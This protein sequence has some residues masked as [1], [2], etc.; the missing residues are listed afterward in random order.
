[1]AAS[2]TTSTRFS[3][4][5]IWY[6]VIREIVNSISWTTDATPAVIE[7]L[8]LDRTGI[9]KTT[10]DEDD[11]AILQEIYA[12]TNGFQNAVGDSITPTAD[13]DEFS[14]TVAELEPN[15]I[16]NPLIAGY[17]DRLENKRKMRGYEAQD[18]VKAKTVG[19]R[20]QIEQGV[21][22]VTKDFTPKT[23]NYNYP[24]R[25]WLV[26]EETSTQ[27]WV[28][29]LIPK[30]H[31]VDSAALN[32]YPP[33]LAFKAWLAD[34]KQSGPDVGSD[35]T[36]SADLSIRNYDIPV[37]GG[38]LRVRYG[39]RGQSRDSDT[40]YQWIRFRFDRQ[41]T[42]STVN[43][44]TDDLREY[45]QA[46]TISLA[47]ADITVPVE[48]GDYN[49]IAKYQRVDIDENRS[50][51]HLHNMTLY[52]G[53]VVR[54]GRLYTLPQGPSWGIGLRYDELAIVNSIHHIPFI[55]DMNAVHVYGLSDNAIIQIDN[56]R[57]TVRFPGTDRQIAIHNIDTTY[58][59]EVQDWNGNQIVIL[60]P[61]E[62]FEFRITLDQN[63]RVGRMIDEH[64]PVR[65]YE[66]IVG[67]H[68]VGDMDDI[69][70]L[71]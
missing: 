36:N 27:F 10:D 69:G 16:V 55:A 47:S 65:V 43:V 4:V 67:D 64:I 58:N 3:R 62:H 61:G 31:A 68:D 34:I 28:E 11:L 54:S 15:G 60:M 32:D 44:D 1:M 70:Y 24:M 22:L 59:V 45:F 18:L 26:Y 42:G 56:P 46:L 14:T 40:E 7:S 9:A 38:T 25:R 50:I 53:K 35:V 30:H 6:D 48:Y 17:E 23:E 21:D 33:I 63:G 2:I 52:H 13:I 51:E 37:S 5:K 49:A 8:S 19:G 66:D 12:S 20:E 29:L 57:I 41:S 39:N 71:T